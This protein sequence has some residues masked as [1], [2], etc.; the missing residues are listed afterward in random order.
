MSERVA[1]S[2]TD[3]RFDFIIVPLAGIDADTVHD[4]FLEYGESLGYN[5]SFTLTPAASAR[6]GENTGG[7]NFPSLARFCRL[8]EITR[9]ERRVASVRSRAGKPGARA[10]G[11]RDER[12][13]AP[14]SIAR[15]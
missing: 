5:T 15:M 1:N 10:S 9:D 8:Q 11:P 4:L 12:R 6:P 13:K 14:V 2:R 3:M 7:L